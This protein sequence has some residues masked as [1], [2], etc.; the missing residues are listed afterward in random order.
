MCET[1]I[2]AVLSV[3]YHAA[4]REEILSA[5]DSLQQLE[6]VQHFIGEGKCSVCISNLMLNTVIYAER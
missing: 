2:G 3:F 1:G 5:T 6:R 4:L